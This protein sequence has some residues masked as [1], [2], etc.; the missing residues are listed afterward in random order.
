[1]GPSNQSCLGL[2]FEQTAVSGFWFDWPS[3]PDLFPVSLPGVMKSAARF[4]ARAVR[5]KLQKRSRLY[6]SG[7]VR[8]AYR[9]FDERWL[10]W[11]KEGGLLD[12][13]RPDC[14]P[15]V[16]EENLWLSAA[17]H[18]RKGADEPQ[19][20]PTE[21]IGSLHLIERGALM[22]PAWLREDGR[23]KANTRQ[24][25]Y[26]GEKT[27]QHYP[28]RVDASVE[29]LFHHVLAIMHGPRYREANT[30]AP[31]MEWP[32]IP[33]PGWLSGRA[34]GAAE[35]LARSAERGR[36]L[37]VLLGPDTPVSGVTETSFNPNIG[38]IAAPAT[39]SG[40]NMTGEVFAVTAGWGHFGQGDGVMPGHGR[41][42]QR[43]FSSDELAEMGA[44][45]PALGVRTFD[46]Y[47]NGEAC[48]CNVPAAIWNYRLGG[49]QVLKKWLSYRE[50]AVL[51]RALLDDEIQHFMDT[52]RRIAAI[53][54]VTISDFG[55]PGPARS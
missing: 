54:L 19:T 49:Y 41:S 27:V 3:L 20:F 46:S 48:W 6:E 45:I 50:R 13:P 43:D 37:A 30:G 36:K 24:A 32:R 22:C 8:F 38:A 7:F 53:L 51:G 5:D 44:T 26:A 12:R 1:M 34:H 29:D 4:D 9:P 2:P 23:A 40:R 25:K 33:L 16:F 39:V 11:E 52:A 35:E 31:R 17:Q 10:Y 21:H 55:Q 15:H 14:R 42:V 18:L 47:L 28:D